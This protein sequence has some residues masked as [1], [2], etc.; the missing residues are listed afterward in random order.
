MRQLVGNGASPTL[1]WWSEKWSQMVKRRC[2]FNILVRSSSFSVSRECKF[3]SSSNIICVI[4][5]RRVRWSVR[6]ARMDDRSWYSFWSEQL[7]GWDV[8][9]LKR[10]EQCETRIVWLRAGSSGGMLPARYNAVGF[11]ERWGSYCLI[12]SPKSSL[13]CGVLGG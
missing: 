4:K 10:N 5:K 6:V 12:S 2:G 9:N 7:K 11:H 13:P 8:W 3:C 1:F